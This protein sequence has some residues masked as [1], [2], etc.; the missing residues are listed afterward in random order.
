MQNQ[1]SID[2]NF[3]KNYFLLKDSLQNDLNEFRIST[4]ESIFSCAEDILS[5][6]SFILSRNKKNL[7]NSVDLFYSEA[8]TALNNIKTKLGKRNTEEQRNYG[9]ENFKEGNYVESAENISP[10]ISESFVL[11]EDKKDGE[12]ISALENAVEKLYDINVI[13]EVTSGKFVYFYEIKKR[14]PRK[15]W[16]WKDRIS[17]ISGFL[18]DKKSLSEKEKNEI[19]EIMTSLNE[20]KYLKYKRGDCFSDLNECFR[21]YL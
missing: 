18:Q 11:C 6:Y 16:K 14:K 20:N 7:E 19:R 5:K 17:Y 13:S 3:F 4:F 8:K 12:K 9:S 2:G 1:A 15:L 21:R 10:F